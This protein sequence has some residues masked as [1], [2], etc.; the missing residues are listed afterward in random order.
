MN[1]TRSTCPV[2]GKNSGWDFFDRIYCISLSTRPDRQRQAK[3]QF[4]A[5]GLTGRVR[6]F[7]ATPHPR[8]SEQGIYESHLACLT[9][10][11]DE[12]ADTILIFEDDVVFEGFSQNRLREWI[13]FLAASQWQAF[14][15]GCLMRRA[16]KTETPSVIA[17]HYQ[18]L[19][20]AYAVNR[21]LA[22]EIVK[23][24]WQ[25]TPYDGMLM[26]FAV[27]GFFA[28]NPGVA[29][30]GDAASDNTRLKQL[31]RIRRHCGGLA[32][33]QKANQWICL[34]TRLLLALHLGIPAALMIVLLFLY[35]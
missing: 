25:G 1:P 18:S 13:T 8:N 33:I 6:F 14:F 30:Q 15:L 10:A 34:H 17:I 29:F 7:L 11:L 16:E 22:L 31:D 28:A 21:C 3:A 9:Q 19:A 24:P 12:G 5:V 27:T 35:W 23:K 20:H 26:R 2:P 32:R 4:D